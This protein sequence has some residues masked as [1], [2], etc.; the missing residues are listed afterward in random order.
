M[1]TFRI[2]S[3]ADILPCCREPPQWAKKMALYSITSSAIASS[4]GECRGEHCWYAPAGETTAGHPF[5]AVPPLAVCTEH[6]A[7][8]N[9]TACRRNAH[10]SFPSLRRSGQIVGDY[11]LRF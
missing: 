11:S 6:V 10:L 5:G 7:G 1:L 9:R 3:N 8:V 2:L 4:I